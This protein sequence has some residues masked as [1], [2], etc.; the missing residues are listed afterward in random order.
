MIYLFLGTK[1]Q[2]AYSVHTRTLT[3]TQLRLRAVTSR[4]P[5][6]KHDDADATTSITRRKL[7]KHLT[8]DD[9][10]YYPYEKFGFQKQITGHLPSV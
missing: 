4:I 7:S 6:T 5:S 9:P 10:V 3:P 8:V 2:S 1:C